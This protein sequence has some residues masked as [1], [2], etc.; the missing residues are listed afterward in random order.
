MT[1][2]AKCDHSLRVG[3]QVTHGLEGGGQVSRGQ[4]AG[5][6]AHGLGWA[7]QVAH[8]LGGRS[9]GSWWGRVGQVDHGGEGGRSGGS[10]SAPST[11]VQNQTHAHTSENITRTMYVVGKNCISGPIGEIQIPRVLHAQLYLL[12][13]QVET[14]TSIPR[15]MNL[16]DI[17]NVIDSFN[18]WQKV[19]CS[20]Q[21]KMYN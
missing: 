14:M 18:Q 9:G 11:Y 2:V 8:G 20:K 13:H 12:E 19:K 16:V 4:G 10:R 17:D 7:G 21:F 5:Q 6:M 15:S 1:T 3:G